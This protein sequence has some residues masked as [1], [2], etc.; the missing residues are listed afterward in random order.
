MDALGTVGFDGDF[1]EAVGAPGVVGG[2]GVALFPVD[3]G[4]DAEALGD[5]GHQ[6]VESG[7]AHVTGF[8]EE[9]TH[10]AFELHR[11]GNDVEGLS[12][13][14]GGDG[15]D[16]GVEGVGVSTGDGLEGGDDL[17]SDDDRVVGFVGDGGVATSAFERYMESV[18]GGHHWAVAGEEFADFF[19]GPTVEAIN[20]VGFVSEDASAETAVFDH[21]ESASSAFFGGLEEEEDVVAAGGFLH[22]GADRSDEDGGVAVVSAGVH[23]AVGLAGVGETGFFVDGEGVHVGAEGDGFSAGLGGGE[24]AE[25]A[26][27]SGE[28]G[29]ELYARFLEGGLDLGGGALFFIHELRMLVEVVAEVGDLFDVGFDVLAETH[30]LEVTACGRG[31]DRIWI[32]R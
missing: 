16:D 2:D 19:A 15:D 18:G 3:L 1:S 14:D 7:F 24:V 10:G 23:F 30:G 6:L 28:A 22:E 20:D 25:D 12:G 29:F 27:A 21:F 11:F 5:G 26:G 9:G 32:W 8:V 17:G 13:V 4:L 31:F